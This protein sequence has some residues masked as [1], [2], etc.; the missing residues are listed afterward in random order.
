MY[1]IIIN[2]LVDVSDFYHKGMHDTLELQ[3]VSDTAFYEHY[4]IN[5]FLAN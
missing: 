1:K 3:N 2:L 5:G 4:F